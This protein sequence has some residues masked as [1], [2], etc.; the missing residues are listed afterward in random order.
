LN[1]PN[2]AG[3]SGAVEAV[4]PNKQRSSDV[5]ETCCLVRG[6]TC[7]EEWVQCERCINAHMRTVPS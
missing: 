1:R 5:E 4:V 3:F 2:V 7:D 6:E